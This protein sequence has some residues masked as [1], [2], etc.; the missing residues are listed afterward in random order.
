MFATSVEIEAASHFPTRWGAELDR[1]TPIP[2]SFAR[3]PTIPNTAD[4]SARR[5]SEAADIDDAGNDIANRRRQQVESATKVY[6]L[7]RR[8]EDGQMKLNASILRERLVEIREWKDEYVRPFSSTFELISWK[9]DFGRVLIFVDQHCV[10]C[11]PYFGPK[12]AHCAHVYDVMR[13]AVDRVTQRTDGAVADAFNKQ[14]GSVTTRRRLMAISPNG[15]RRAKQKI[16]EINAQMAQISE[17]LHSTPHKETFQVGRDMIWYQ[18][19][20]KGPSIRRY[21]LREW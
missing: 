17:R 6:A 14:L 2:H 15:D 8:D 21:L 10:F 13:V 11:R 9:Q 4:L 16:A 12:K 18:C 19:N 20:I 1:N 5:D 3:I 7:L